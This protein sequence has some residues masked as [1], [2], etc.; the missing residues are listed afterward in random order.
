MAS[1]ETARALRAFWL[2]TERRRHQLVRVMAYFEQSQ[3]T[4]H[5]DAGDERIPCLDSLTPD[6]QV[7]SHVL[8]T[9]AR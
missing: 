1:G 8:T 5:S 4:T 7:Q 3:Q 2:I 9:I 6:V